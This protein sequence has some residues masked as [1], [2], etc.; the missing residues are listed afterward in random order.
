[1]Y[2]LPIPAARAVTHV[3]TFPS[4]DFPAVWVTPTAT[5]WAPF[6]SGTV[7]LSRIPAAGGSTVSIQL[8]T[9]GPEAAN[10]I[11]AAGDTFYFGQAVNTSVAGGLFDVPDTFVATTKPTHLAS[12]PLSP[13]AAATCAVGGGTVTWVDNAHAGLGVWSRPYTETANSVSLGRT[14]LLATDGFAGSD[15]E[16]LLPILADAGSTMAYFAYNKQPTTYPASVWLHS[17]GKNSLVSPV[18]APIGSLP[19]PPMSFSGPWLLYPTEKT[20]GT[21]WFGEE[22]LDTATGRRTALAMTGVE[23]YALGSGRLVWVDDNGSVWQ[24]PVGTSTATQLASPLGAGDTV[25]AVEGL[26]SAGDYVAWDY[27]WASKTKSGYV[28]A[29]MN[30]TTKTT[31]TIPSTKS[32]YAISLSSQYLGVESQSNLYAIELSS[33]APTEHLL[34]SNST[35][36]S[37]SGDVGCWIGDSSDLPFAGK[38]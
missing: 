29:Y 22:L 8:P 17:G 9:A 36:L 35:A 20:S 1:V 14:S 2:R 25:G 11:V 12:P 24:E 37:I 19:Y 4:D 15:P 7:T 38:I 13:R 33:P 23:E 18:G 34:A 3:V 32:V 5:A 30:V 21:S 6:V 31:R 16:M 26:A 10:G 27:Y 28:G